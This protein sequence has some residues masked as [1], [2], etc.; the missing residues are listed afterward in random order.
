ML[1]MFLVSS[2]SYLLAL[3]THYQRRAQRVRICPL[4][5]TGGSGK[6]VGKEAGGSSRE[7]RSRTEGAC[8]RAEKGPGGQQGIN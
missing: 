8:G 4:L 5:A 7:G 3:L 1:F 6:K 2:G